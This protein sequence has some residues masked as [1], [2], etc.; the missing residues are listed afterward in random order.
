MTSL[1]ISL[2][3]GPKI[4]SFINAKYAMKYPRSVSFSAKLWTARCF[5]DRWWHNFETPWASSCRVWFLQNISGDICAGQNLIVA[6]NFSCWFLQHCNRK[7]PEKMDLV[8]KSQI[9]LLKFHVL[10]VNCL[11][12]KGSSFLFQKAF[13]HSLL[14]ICRS[15]FSMTLSENKKRT[16]RRVATNRW[17][18]EKARWARYSSLCRISREDTSRVKS[19]H[20]SK[21]WLKILSLSWLPTDIVHYWCIHEKI[22]MSP[23][24]FPCCQCSIHLVLFVQWHLVAV[25]TKLN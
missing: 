2:T 4:L 23:I 7:I 3:N 15:F 6:W 9:H 21:L 18:L 20:P 1:N 14:C 16:G 24:H 19:G 10:L 5:L 12:E 11:F 8:R 13:I 22:R 25:Y 17:Y